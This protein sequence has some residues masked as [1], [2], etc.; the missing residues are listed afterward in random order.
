MHR[1][2]V[3]IPPAGGFSTDPEIWEMAEVHDPSSVTIPSTG[4]IQV[5]GPDNKVITLQMVAR[6]YDDTVSFFVEHGA[7]EQW[8]FLN[9]G[10]PNLGGL[11]HPMHIHLTSFQALS[12]DRY[13]TSTYIP[14][15]RGNPNTG[16]TAA[17][18]AYIGPG[19]LDPNEQ[20]W[21]D[22]IRVGRGELVSVAGQFVGGNGRFVYH[23]HL[24]DHEDM[25]M[26]R[27]F[28]V[29]PAEVLKLMANGGGGH[30]G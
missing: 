11:T 24:L 27:P 18:A 23:C 28:N 3:L 15:I 5:Q 22:T 4:V 2:I 17:P 8:K 16:G 1:W 12:R 29:R 25:G 20:G 30:H 7:W 13:D 10:D 19:I 14:L 6:H 9:I 21:K 26:M